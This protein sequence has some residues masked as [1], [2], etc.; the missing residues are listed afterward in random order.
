M[1]AIIVILLVIFSAIA[2]AQ[3]AVKLSNNKICHA[4][5]GQLK[6]PYYN[7]IKNY[8]AYHSLDACLSAGGRLP[9]GM[10]ASASTA[11]N[12]KPATNKANKYS[13][14]QFGHGWDDSDNDCQNTRHEILIERSTVKPVLTKNTCR[15]VHG[16]WVSSFTGAVI[17]EAAFID[18]DHVVPLKW[19]WQHGAYDWAYDRRKQF[20]NDPANLIAVERSLNR[21]KG[22]KGPDQWLPPKNQC[23]YI[24]RF[25]RVSKR[26]ALPLS[27]TIQAQVTECLQR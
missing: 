17:M 20:A 15:A 22:A 10:A 8:T 2:H 13:R 21:E 14:N 4:Q 25:A 24:L 7:R 1:P 12:G 3:P 9:K 6:S 23:Q 19:A 5:E 16:R 18:I 26:Y 11:E 27:E